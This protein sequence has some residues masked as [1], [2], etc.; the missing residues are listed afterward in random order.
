MIKTLLAL[1]ITFVSINSFSAEYRIQKVKVL[2][3]M[4]HKVI[5]QSID[6]KKIKR[7]NVLKGKLVI[8]WGVHVFELV[9]GLYSC[10]KRNL[11]KLSDY[12]R[13]ATFEKCTVK[14]GKKV[15]CRKRL[16]GGPSSEGPS[17]EV[18]INDVPDSVKD[19]MH[20][21]SRNDDSE[22]EFPVRIN[23]EFDDIF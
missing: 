1:M 2:G 9:N 15:E 6:L 16:N 12:E 17:S 8:Q 7:S 3:P 18:I 22:S 20:R 14:G 21:D 23:G 10:D 11:C 13:L 19:D 5:F 4:K